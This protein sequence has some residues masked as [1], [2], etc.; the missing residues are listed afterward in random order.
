MLLGDA[1]ATAHFS[2]GSG[3]KLAM[4]DAIALYGRHRR[5]PTSRLRCRLRARPPRRGGEDPARGRRVARLVRACRALLAF[6]SGA[7]RL[8]RDDPLEGDHLRQSHAAR[9][10]F[11]R[12]GRPGVRRGRSAARASTSTSTIP[13]PP[14]FQPFR[15]REMD[16]PEPRRWSRRCACI[17]PRTAS[18]AIGTW[19]ITVARAS[20]AP[21]SIFTEMTDVSPEARITPGCAGLW[22]DEQEA[23]WKRIVDFVH[24]NSAAKFCLQTRP[25]RPQGRDKT[26]VGGH[27]PAARRRAAGRSSS[28]SPIPYFPDSQVPREMDPRRR[29]TRSWR[30][31]VATAERGER[32]GF[33]MLELHCAHGYLLAS[34]IS[35]LD[36]PAHGR[37][38]RPAG[39]PAALPAR[40]LRARCARRGRR[41]SRCRCASRRP[42][43]P[44]AASPATTRSRSPRAFGEAGVDLVDVSTGQ[45]DARAEPVYGRMFQTPFSD[46][47]RNEAR[48]RHHVRRQHHD[49]RPGQYHPRRRP[50]RPRGARPARIWPTR[51]SP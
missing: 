39:E 29:W 10:G 23:A 44:K 32:A 3:T 38:W 20:A 45:T 42:T 16:A 51:T 17:R 22:N 36:Q 34:F 14:M 25:C 24:A 47:I 33:D 48:A 13:V 40:G 2:I 12:R 46:Q 1:K 7:V 37:L 26:D 41:T 43:G 11:R 8:R 30:R 21:G 31:F 28:A 49:R 6:R 9:A 18:P 4:E 50:R 27:G 5:G 15:L 19:S 35:P